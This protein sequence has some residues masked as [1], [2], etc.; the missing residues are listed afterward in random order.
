MLILTSLL[1]AFMIGWQEGKKRSL[2]NLGKQFSKLALLTLS[3]NV[4]KK[5]W[6]AINKHLS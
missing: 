4:R 5:L 2:L 1:P 6:V 3:T